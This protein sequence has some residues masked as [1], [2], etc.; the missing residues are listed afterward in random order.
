MW[1]ARNQGLRDVPGVHLVTG[2]DLCLLYMIS[3]YHFNGLGYRP[4]Q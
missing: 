4:D 1:V 2:G 3:D